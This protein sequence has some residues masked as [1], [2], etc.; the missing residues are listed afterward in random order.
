MRIFLVFAIVVLCCYGCRYV[1]ARHEEHWLGGKIDRPGEYDLVKGGYK[2]FVGV[3]SDLVRYRVV[4]S[5]GATIIR[6]DDNISVY[7]RWGLYWDAAGNLWVQS[8]DIGDVVWRPV[9]GDKYKKEFLDS[10]SDRLMPEE[11]RRR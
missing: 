4:D 2:I 8:S 9:G 7:Q 5:T 3:D 6:C 1:P 10:S 11:L